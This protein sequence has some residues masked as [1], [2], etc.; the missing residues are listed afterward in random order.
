MKF[1][2]FLF[3]AL[4]SIDAY[5]APHGDELYARHCSSCHGLS[6]KGGV[7]VPLSLPSFLNSVSDEYLEKTI[8]F[9]RTGRI[10]PA[11]DEL[12]DAQVSAIVKQVR[13]WSDKPAPAEDTTLVKGD[14]KKGKQLYTKHC[15]QCHGE[16]GGGGKGTGVTFSRKRDLPIIA[17]ALNNTGF[18]ASASDP[19][20]R[21][22]ITHG[23]EGTPMMSMLAA[24]LSRT[25]IDDVVAYIRSFETSAAK[26]KESLDGSDAES[27]VITAVS[28]YS[29]EETIENLKQAI[30]DQNFTLIRT[31][32]LD[33]GLVEKGK[34]NHKQVVLHFCNFG[35]L[36]DALAIDPRVGMFLPCRVTVVEKDG[37]VTL[38]AI[39]P[40]RLSKLFNN[41]ELDK[42][43]NE[44]Y[45]VYNTLLED[46]TL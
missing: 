37:K 15:A 14:S 3:L 44:M 21:D 33:H 2:S 46:A 45:E 23:R 32:Y 35:F 16:T 34:E 43:C 25:D 20:I 17:P 11:F 42:S 1:F 29:L 9:G 24:G 4:F 18:L 5:S 41:H 22:T 8:R 12:S 7:G 6:G 36:F 19:M 38:S 31:D 28:P 27:P 40:K 26:L 13:S 30:T 39:N 10:M